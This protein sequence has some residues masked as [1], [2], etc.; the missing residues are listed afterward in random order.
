MNNI[1]I[2]EEKEKEAIKDLEEYLHW[3]EL[4]VGRSYKDFLC[5]QE[6]NI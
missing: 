5:C 6:I 1:D 2:L 3:E 4:Q